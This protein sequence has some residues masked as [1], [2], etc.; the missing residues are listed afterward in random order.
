MRARSLVVPA[1]TSLL[2]LAAPSARPAGGQR[3]GGRLPTIVGT[4]GQDR[5]RGTNRADVIVGLAGR[6]IIRGRGG[7]DRVCGNRG[8]DD[9]RGGERRDRLAGNRGNDTLAGGPGRNH[10][11]GGLGKRDYCV[12]ND[13]R[14]S[15]CEL[16]EVP[17]D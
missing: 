9:L 1:L 4:V 8:R 5:I 2:M 3:C 14:H 16:V 10:L 7:R 11:K 15:G 17:G 13:D 12:V 6:D